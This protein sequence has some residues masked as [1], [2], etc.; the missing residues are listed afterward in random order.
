MYTVNPEIEMGSNC[1]S[2]SCKHLSVHR[3][4]AMFFLEYTISMLDRTQIRGSISG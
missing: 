2:A 4:F 1:L 3:V